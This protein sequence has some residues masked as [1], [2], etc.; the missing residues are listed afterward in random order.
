MIKGLD[1]AAAG[2]PGVGRL[3]DQAVFQTVFQESL[4]SAPAARP[5][6]PASDLRTF[7]QGFRDLE[8]QLRADRA[9]MMRMLAPTSATGEA[10]GNSHGSHTQYGM[11]QGERGHYQDGASRMLARDSDRVRPIYSDHAARSAP[12]VV[13]SAL[14]IDPAVDVNRIDFAGEIGAVSQRLEGVMGTIRERIADAGPKSAEQSVRHNSEVQA[15]IREGDKLNT[16]R[17]MM[18]SLHLAAHQET[19]T[20]MLSAFEHMAGMVK[21]INEIFNQ[22]KQGS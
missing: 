17:S 22:L 12:P 4:A 15:L 13:H 21:K 7:G 19:R 20:R 11:A 14:G 5:L 3:P 1:P 16:E 8:H 2:Q 9:S 6:D 10:H 18:M